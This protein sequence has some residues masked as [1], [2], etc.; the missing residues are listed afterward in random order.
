LHR[1]AVSYWHAQQALRRHCAAE[2]GYELAP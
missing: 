2:K 1:S